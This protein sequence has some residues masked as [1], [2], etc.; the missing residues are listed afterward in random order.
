MKKK[1][2][3]ILVITSMIFSMLPTAAFAETVGTFKVHNSATLQ[4]EKPDTAETVTWKSS[5]KKIATVS[6]E[7]VVKGI[8][9]GKCTIT[10]K[11]GKKKMT[12]KI[13]VPS[14]YEG[15]KK[16]PDFGALYGKKEFLS[17]ELKQEMLDEM[18]G[19]DDNP[20]FAEKIANVAHIRIY[21][22]KNSKQAK[23]YIKK[24]EKKLKKSKFKKSDGV[25]T[26]KSLM[27]ATDRASKN[28][29]VFYLDLNDLV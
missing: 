28:I 17:D 6:K 2:F 18:V 24:Y 8:K 5:N 27:L 3:S 14:Y 21:N 7:G 4:L 20:V 25:W 10:A 11:F 15:F 9:A 16:I 22:T 26:K 29:I 12:F 19:E 13:T 1:F 23:S